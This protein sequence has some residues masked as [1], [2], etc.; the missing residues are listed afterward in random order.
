MLGPRK[1]IAH[2]IAQ[3]RE[4]T[5][6]GIE[7]QTAQQRKRSANGVEVRSDA[8]GGA[9]GDGSKSASNKLITDYFPGF[10]GARKPVSTAS[11]E[12]PRVEKHQ[13]G[14]GQKRA[15]VKN[16]VTN[17]KL[18]DVPSWCCVPGTPFRVVSSKDISNTYI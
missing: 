5:S 8:L 9:V 15:V 11:R 4:G 6:S 14:S 10:G 12:Q 3:L 2:A 18:R 17:R 7:A 1:K 13:T 16:H